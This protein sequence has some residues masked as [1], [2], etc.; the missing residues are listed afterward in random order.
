MKNALTGIPK[1]RNSVNGRNFYREQTFIVVNRI[2]SF[3]CQ[4]KNWKGKEKNPAVKPLKEK[5]GG[6]RLGLKADLADL[7]L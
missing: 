4:E 2:L 7:L 5:S 3:F 1:W 6:G